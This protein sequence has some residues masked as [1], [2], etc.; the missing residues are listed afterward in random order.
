MN[1][2]KSTINTNIPLDSQHEKKKNK[3]MVSQICSELED[4][5]FNK[6]DCPS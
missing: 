1:S 6:I 3:C 4:M 5:V 2:Y